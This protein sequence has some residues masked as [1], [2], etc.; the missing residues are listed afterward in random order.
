LIIKIVKIIKVAPTCFGSHKTIIGEPY[1]VL[2]Q[3]YISGTNVRVDIDVVSVM[4]AYLHRFKIIE[5][6]TCPCGAGD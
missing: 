3:D 1:P 4:A 5:A 6:P 2:S